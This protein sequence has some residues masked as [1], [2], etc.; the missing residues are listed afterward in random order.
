M[1]HTLQNCRCQMAWCLET[2]ICIVDCLLYW[3]TLP[4]LN[5]LSVVC[6]SVQ[7]EIIYCY[8]FGGGKSLFALPDSR[9][10]AI[11]GKQVWIIN[12]G[13]VV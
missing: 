6:N 12:R 5:N 1:L 3:Q 2:M 7:C 10:E 9:Q 8:T 11:V 13:G 4:M